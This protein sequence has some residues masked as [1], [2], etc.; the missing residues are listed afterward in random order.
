METQAVHPPD[1][2]PHLL[3]IDDDSRIRDLLSRYLGNHGF[4]VTV[5]DSAAAARRKLEALT[6]DALV[7]DVMMPGESGLELTSALRKASDV[8]ILMLTART[9][10]EHRI[11][12]LEV[13]ADDYLSK[14]FE[15][16]ELLLRLG[17]LLKRGDAKPVGVPTEVRFGPFTFHLDRRE[18]KKGDDLIRLT[19]RERGLLRIFAEKPGETVPRHLLI[20]GDGNLGERTADVQI[21][22]LRR[23]LEPDPTN[24]IYL[25]TVRGVGY[26]LMCD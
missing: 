9:E 11:E 23:K 5:A 15:P 6:F 8:P 16:R 3:V 1:D 2:A 21:N 19:D 18:L 20:G 10:V 7:I 14:P 4:R 17:N 13:G 22:R 25:Q 26:R 12:G 24:P